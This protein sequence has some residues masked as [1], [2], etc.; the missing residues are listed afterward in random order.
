[1][2]REY[3]FKM[4]SQETVDDIIRLANNLLRDECGDGDITLVIWDEDV[5]AF[6]EY[7]SDTKNEFELKLH[8]VR[9]GIHYFYS[10]MSNQNLHIISRTYHDSGNYRLPSWGNLI[11]I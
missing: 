6:N 9:V 3:K 4:Y 7:Y 8:S 5:D 11:R 1:M 2:R 10:D